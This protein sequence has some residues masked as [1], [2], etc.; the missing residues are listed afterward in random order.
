MI[1]CTVDDYAW[2]MEGADPP[3]PRCQNQSESYATIK[4]SYEYEYS[5]QNISNIIVYWLLCRVFPKLTSLSTLL[6]GELFNIVGDCKTPCLWTDFTPHIVNY[7]EPQLVG[8]GEL[9]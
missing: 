9:C 5:L 8:S 7:D 4:A 2:V 6:Q 3:V 1:N